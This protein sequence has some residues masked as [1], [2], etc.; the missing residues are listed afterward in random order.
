M[1]ENKEYTAYCG[2]YCGD[3]I[4]FN[5]LLFD[6]VEKIR[7]ELHKRQ[8]DKYAEL[9]AKEN[10]VFN[11]YE[12]FV[13]VLSSLTELKC[14]K[15][16]RENGGNPDCKIRACARE[17]EIKGCW[18]CSYFETCELLEPLSDYHGATPKNNLR[19]IKKYGI[20]NW[21]DKRGRHYIW[22]NIK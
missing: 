2:L 3:C 12:T 13:R 22:N 1:R 9:M 21:A 10:P 6:N 4:P 16:C 17:K 14:T 15:T 18:E 7:E 19:L 5:Q 11:D 8:F 20:E